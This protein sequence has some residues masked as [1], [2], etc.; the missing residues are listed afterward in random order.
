MQHGRLVILK[1]KVNSYSGVVMPNEQGPPPIESIIADAIGRTDTGY[2]LGVHMIGLNGA[3]HRLWVMLYLH[4]TIGDAEEGIQV[5]REHVDQLLGRQITD[6]EFARLEE[7]AKA[8][9]AE[10]NGSAGT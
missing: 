1:S 2:A 8:Y 5:V 4:A 10:M 6:A 9:A 7:H 3:W